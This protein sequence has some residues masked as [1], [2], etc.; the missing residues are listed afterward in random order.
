MVGICGGDD[1]GWQDEDGL[2]GAAAF[3]VVIIECGK[4]KH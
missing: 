2:K 1:V 4:M 3:R